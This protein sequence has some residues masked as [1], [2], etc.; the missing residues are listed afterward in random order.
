[1]STVYSEKTWMN[2]TARYKWEPLYS[3]PSKL[4]YFIEPF[5]LQFNY[6]YTF[7]GKIFK[8]QEGKEPK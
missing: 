7:Q 4:E 1:M 3:H 8:R 2:V 6:N 5:Y